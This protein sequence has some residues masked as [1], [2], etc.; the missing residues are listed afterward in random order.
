MLRATFNA[1]GGNADLDLKGQLECDWSRLS[2][3]LAPYLGDSV[4]IEGRDKREF[5]VR[6]PIRARSM[7][8][9]ASPAGA[10]P[11]GRLIRS[12]GS[13]HSPHRQ[14]SAG[15]GPRHMVFTSGKA[16]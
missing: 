9:A 1:I 7:E 13:N 3:L 4:R 8:R 2:K 16:S 14:A 6:G 15:S 10:S 12:S 5:A 11:A